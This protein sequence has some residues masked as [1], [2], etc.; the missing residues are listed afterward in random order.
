MKTN[1]ESDIQLTRTE[2]SCSCFHSWLSGGRRRN[3][4]KQAMEKPTKP[5]TNSSSF[6]Q[7]DVWFRNLRGT[8]RVL[9]PMQTTHPHPSTWPSQVWGAVYSVQ[10]VG[11]VHNMQKVLSRERLLSLHDLLKWKAVAYWTLRGS[12]EKGEIPLMDALKGARQLLQNANLRPSW[13]WWPLLRSRQCSVQARHRA[14]G[15]RQIL[16]PSQRILIFRCKMAAAEDLYKVGNLIG[17]PTRY[18]SLHWFQTEKLREISFYFHCFSPFGFYS[19]VWK[20]ELGLQHEHEKILDISL[21]F[22]TLMPPYRVT[23]K[24]SFLSCSTP[25]F[26]FFGEFLSFLLSWQQPFP[27]LRWKC[28]GFQ[29]DLCNVSSRHLLYRNVHK[30]T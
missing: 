26:W 22:T 17:I 20:V 23:E 8:E 4:S 18:W 6:V 28:Q 7:A 16:I 19:K 11:A 25:G 21:W 12:K 24:F 10:K 9:M 15:M 3:Q 13:G 5:A 30:T 14:E 29:K 1:P 27:W 2:N